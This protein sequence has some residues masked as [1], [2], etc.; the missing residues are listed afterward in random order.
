MPKKAKKGSS[1]QDCKVSARQEKGNQAYKQGDFDRAVALY[2]RGLETDPSNAVLWSN[3]A[4]ALI[5]LHRPEEALTDANK[6]IEC[7][8]AF[9][10]AYFRK[11]DALRSVDR[12]AEALEVVA[13]A[14]ARFGS[15]AEFESLQ[16]SL[17]T[18]LLEDQK[19]PFDHPERVKFS[20]L[21]T[22]LKSGGALFPKLKMR[23]YSVDFRGVH[24]TTFI[25]VGSM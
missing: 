3:R 17:E 25:P 21:E 19:V 20:Q 11:A 22:W 4:A 14:S 9:L 1:A 7:D 23:F 2:S 18:E 8:S 6:A 13:A 10:K 15:N 5:A 12:L 16:T 24:C